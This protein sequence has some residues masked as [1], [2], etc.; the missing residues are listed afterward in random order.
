MSP[1]ASSE[2]GVVAVKVNGRTA[3]VKSAMTIDGERKEVKESQGKS[4]AE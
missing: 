3:K 4:R 1:I 2:R